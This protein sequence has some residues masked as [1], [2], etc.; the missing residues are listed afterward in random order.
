RLAGTAQPPYTVVG[1]SSSGRNPAQ[2]SALF[3]SAAQA[4]A[5]Y[6]HPGS[7]DLIGLLARPA[8]SA[9]ALAARVRTVLAGR[10]LTVSARTAL[11]P[12]ADLA[13]AADK[14]NLAALAGS[15][16]TDVV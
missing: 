6:G 9:P 8:A 16:G 10:H 3:W 7:A 14:D 11:G 1:V 12:A 15:A 4:S 2:D 5:R 13:V